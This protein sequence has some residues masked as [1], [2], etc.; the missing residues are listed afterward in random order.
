MLFR[1]K[2]RK[3]SSLYTPITE[4]PTNQP[5]VK[6]SI[7]DDEWAEE[8]IKASSSEN[9]SVIEGAVIEG[10]VVQESNNPNEDWPENP[11]MIGINERGDSVLMQDSVSP[12]LPLQNQDNSYE[13]VDSDSEQTQERSEDRNQ[14]A[15]LAPNLVTQTADEKPKK[16]KRT[17]AHTR[18]S[19]VLKSVTPDDLAAAFEQAQEA[20]KLA[21]EAQD[22][23]NKIREALKLTVKSKEI[24]EL[25]DAILSL[26]G[27]YQTNHDN[28]IE[29]IMDRLQKK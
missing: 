14:Q 18:T 9:N 20:E 8:L 5:T 13:T 17:S 24:V 11:M 27:R 4:V 28:V 26:A 6:P 19:K 2:D 12:T 10:S 23:L 25:S 21:K 1:I 7:V 3:M 15:Y 29:L 16:V 22:R